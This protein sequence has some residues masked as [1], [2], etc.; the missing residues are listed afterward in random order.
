MNHHFFVFESA[1]DDV[2]HARGLDDFE[3][4]TWPIVEEVIL[5]RAVI[6]DFLSKN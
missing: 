3:I 4:I 1:F 2:I 6:E 5:R